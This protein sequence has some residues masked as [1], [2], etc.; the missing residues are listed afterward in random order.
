MRNPFL[1][2]LMLGTAVAAAIALGALAIGAA[3]PTPRE[4]PAH[5]AAQR[6]PASEIEQALTIE[7]SD[8]A[9]SQ[10]SAVP[11]GPTGPAVARP[12]PEITP[13]ATS[14]DMKSTCA[15]E[16]HQA[17]SCPGAQD[18]GLVALSR[19]TVAVDGDLESARTPSGRSSRA[20]ERRVSSGPMRM[21]GGGESTW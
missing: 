21:L 14:D 13:S 1:T 11:A 5:S 7:V 10:A 2:R 4:N 3:L 12:V 17:S 15:G 8:P 6:A 16:R 19:P 20:A 18:A 9:P